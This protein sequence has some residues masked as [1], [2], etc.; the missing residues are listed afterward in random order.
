[1]NPSYIALLRSS[2]IFKAKE[3]D[4][5]LTTYIHLGTKRPFINS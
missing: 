3:K 1:L 5:Y 2:L 4:T